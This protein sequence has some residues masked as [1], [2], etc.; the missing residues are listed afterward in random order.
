MPEPKL[1]LQSI[2]VNTAS[3]DREGRLVLADREL[4]AVLVRLDGE[5][6]GGLRGS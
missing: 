1:M 5:E 4:I 2:R 3:H 6:H